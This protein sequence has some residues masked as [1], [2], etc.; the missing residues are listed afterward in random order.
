MFPVLTS[1]GP[2]ASRCVRPG[3]RGAACGSCSGPG[4]R[5]DPQRWRCLQ[6]GRPRHPPQARSPHRR[7]ARPPPP[8]PP[9]PPLAPPRPPSPACPRRAETQ[10]G[11]HQVSCVC[12]WEV[13]T[14]SGRIR[15]GA[16]VQLATPHDCMRTGASLLRENT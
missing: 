16:G 4:H 11:L 9:P 1:D 2:C 12:R 8:P 13:A 3:L 6:H 5:L 7:G 10:H 15:T 14:G